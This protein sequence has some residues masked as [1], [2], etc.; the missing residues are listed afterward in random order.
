MLGETMRADGD[1][2]QNQ[3]LRNA[4]DKLEEAD[5]FQDLLSGLCYQQTLVPVSTLVIFSGNEESKSYPDRFTLEEQI[6]FMLSAFV[7]ACYS[8]VE[9]VRRERRLHNLAKEFCAKHPDFY[10]SGPTGGIRTVATH[11]RPVFP[12]QAEGVEHITPGPFDLFSDEELEEMG[13]VF[14]GEPSPFRKKFYLSPEGR[15]DPLPVLCQGHHMELSRFLGECRRA[16]R[17]D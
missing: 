9:H 12:V 13:A 1:L 8:V 7:N 11:F 3:Q 5:F 2:I 4:Y 17:E 6:A 15:Q 16:L 14:T 10:G